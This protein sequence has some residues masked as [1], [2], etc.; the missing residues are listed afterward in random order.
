MSRSTSDQFAILADATTNT[1][2]ALGATVVQGHFIDFVNY[3]ASD[4][5]RA[6][7]LLVALVHPMLVAML[8]APRAAMAIMELVMKC[9]R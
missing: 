3:G 1:L 8:G 4:I 5:L 2:E 9:T 6:T 7:V